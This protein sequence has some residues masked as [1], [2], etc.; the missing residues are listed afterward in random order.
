MLCVEG[1]NY[2]DLV[3]LFECEVKWTK[4][5]GEQL[6]KSTSAVIFTKE[7]IRF[8]RVTLATVVS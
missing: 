6:G 7:R 3:A 1:C 8:K 5:E 4:P 2:G